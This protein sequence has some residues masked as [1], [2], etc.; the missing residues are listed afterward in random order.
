MSRKPINA[1]S[2]LDRLAVLNGESATHYVKACEGSAGKVS[3]KAGVYSRSVN[4]NGWTCPLAI[5]DIKTQ[6]LIKSVTWTVHTLRR[7]AANGDAEAQVII[8]NIESIIKALA[9]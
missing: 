2:G 1:K 4:D 5:D 8:K 9:E 6:G 3:F 7:R